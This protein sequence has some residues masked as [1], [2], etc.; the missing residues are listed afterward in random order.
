MHMLLVP[1]LWLH[2]N[3]D[4]HHGRDILRAVLHAVLFHR[5]MGIVKPYTFD[6][7]DVTIV[8]FVIV[9]VGYVADASL[10]AA[11]D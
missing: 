10:C 1:S 3:A 8:R 9:A 4:R 2:Q 11:C 6:V 7:L 5:L